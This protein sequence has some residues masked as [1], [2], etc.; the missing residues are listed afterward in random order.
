M[1]EFER[2]IRADFPLIESSRCVYLDNG[3]TTQKPECVLTEINRY[4][5]TMNANPM[6]GLYELSVEATEAYENARTVTANFIN[7]KDPR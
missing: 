3:A 5:E 2:K 1:T 7:A 4:Y 6:R